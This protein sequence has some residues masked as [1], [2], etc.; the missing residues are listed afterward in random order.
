MA[1]GRILLWFQDISLYRIQS[2]S[3]NVHLSKYVAKINQIDLKVVFTEK[4]IAQ[5]TGMRPTLPNHD[6]Y[7]QP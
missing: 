4:T 1:R 6:N 3:R 5:D 7:I 2:I